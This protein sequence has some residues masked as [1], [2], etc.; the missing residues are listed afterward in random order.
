MVD[1]C[2]LSHFLALTEDEYALLEPA[3]SLFGTRV[4]DK[5]PQVS[6]D[7]AEAGKCLGLRRPTASVFHLMRVMEVGVQKFG[8]KL[9]VTLADE[10]VWQVILDQINV[11]IKTLGKGQKAKD[12]AAIAAYLYHVKLAWRNE[13]MHPKATYTPEEADNIFR[14]VRSFMTDLVGVL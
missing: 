10:K 12:Y 6:E 14:A 11:H 5:L 7:I 1:E 8:E 3:A 4:E 2:S 9:G 13:T